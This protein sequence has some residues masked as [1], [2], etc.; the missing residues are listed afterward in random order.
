MHRQLCN[1]PWN[2]LRGEKFTARFTGI[3]GI[4]GDQKLVGITKEIDVVILK[5]PKIETRNALEHGGQTAVFVFDG[6]TQAVAGGV[7]IGKETFYFHFGGVAIGGTVDSGE[8]CGQIGVKAFVG[9]GSAGDV[10]K[11]LARVDEIAFG[12]C[13]I[14][15]DCWGNDRIGERCVLDAFITTFDVTCKVFADKTIEECT[16]YILFEIPPIDRATNIV[17]YFPDLGL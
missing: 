12:F 9:V 5:L 4:V 13:G 15:F 17:G 10:G 1:E 14:I 7:K 11:E 6:V 16:Q 2:L 3:G 8:D